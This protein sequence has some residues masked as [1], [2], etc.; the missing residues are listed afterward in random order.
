M[1]GKILGRDIRPRYEAP[2]AADI[3]H[4]L[5]DISRARSSGYSPNY[6]IEDGLAVT[7]R[8]YQGK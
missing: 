4:S 2:R 1:I 3:R 5:A 6:S 7:I 8:W